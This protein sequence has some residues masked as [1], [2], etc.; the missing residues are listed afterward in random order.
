MRK[1]LALSFI[2][3]ALSSSTAYSETAAGDVIVVL[4]NQS[5]TRINAASVTSAAESFV[6]SSNLTLRR[7][8]SALSKASNNTFMLVH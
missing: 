5:G 4:R 7:T 1:L 8:Y 6:S 3:A 2:I